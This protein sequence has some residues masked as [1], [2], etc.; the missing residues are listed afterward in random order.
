MRDL[1]YRDKRIYALFAYTFSAEPPFCL[2]AVSDEFH[3]HVPRARR[4]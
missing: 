2:L 1:G 3:F 4:V